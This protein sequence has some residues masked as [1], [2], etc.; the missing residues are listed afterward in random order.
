MASLFVD[1]RGSYAVFDDIAYVHRH[2]VAAV[3]LAHRTSDEKCVATSGA[4][5]IGQSFKNLFHDSFVNRSRRA[6]YDNHGRVALRSRFGSSARRHC[7]SVRRAVLHH[8][9]VQRL[10]RGYGYGAYG[11]AAK[12]K[13]YLVKVIKLA[14]LI[15]QII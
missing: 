6:L 1:N 4:Q 15:L 12:E 7:V 5:Y 2:I 14:A 8:A 13:G 10:L 3:L 9:Y 11:F